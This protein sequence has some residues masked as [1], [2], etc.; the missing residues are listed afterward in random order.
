MTKT[1]FLTAAV[2]IDGVDIVAHFV[3]FILKFFLKMI[4][5]LQEFI[6]IEF[7]SFRLSLMLHLKLLIY[8]ILLAFAFLH[9]NS[10]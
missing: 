4:L 3:F 1:C 6:R 2:E 10:S 9:Q 8:C 5:S 7:K